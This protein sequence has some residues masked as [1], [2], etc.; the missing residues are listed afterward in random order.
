M[1]KI[2]MAP[3]DIFNLPSFGGAGSMMSAVNAWMGSLTA[4]GE[5]QWIGIITIGCAVVVLLMALTGMS[6]ELAKGRIGQ[7]RH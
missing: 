4:M 2:I 1:G 3:F 5:L 7:H 6:A